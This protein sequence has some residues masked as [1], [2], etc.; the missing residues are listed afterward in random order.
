M[1]TKIWDVI[2]VGAGPG[3]SVAA[4]QLALAGAQV[5]LLDKAK[6]PRDKTCGDALSPNGIK[7]LTAMGLV[8]SLQGFAYRLD[9]VRIVAPDGGQMLGPIPPQSGLVNYIKIAPRLRL[10]NML[11]Q[12]ALQAGASYKGGLRV[13]DLCVEQNYVLVSAEKRG[14][15]F[16]FKGQTVVIAVGVSTSLLRRAGFITQLP[17]FAFAARAYFSG[18]AS[19]E[20]LVDFRFDGVPLPGYGWIFP[21]SA[22]TANVGAGLVGNGFQYPSSPKIAFKEFLAHKPIS[23]LLAGGQ[24]EG[25]IKC[26]PMRMDFSTART[27]AQRILVVGESAGLVNPF[28]G[29]GID[30]AMESGQMAAQVLTEKL[31]SGDFS[32]SSL[33]DY[34]RKLR[35][36][37]QKIFVWSLRIRAV[38]MNR[39][40]LNPLVRAGASD[41]KIMQLLLN[42]FLGYRTAYHALAPRTIYH[43]LKN[44]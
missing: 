2:V 21:T 3:G 30:Y 14:Q 11:L 35:A 32:A 41:A 29:E 8:E 12:H 13:R 36:R 6:F 44:L 4:S 5:L 15:V 33:C 19:L 18:L 28:S 23:D 38:Y 25:K 40:M 31:S 42:V 24:I 7:I 26:F 16:Q 34:D 17:R 9:A 1:K 39:W 37:F 20:K 27:Y 43:I 10:D 22:T